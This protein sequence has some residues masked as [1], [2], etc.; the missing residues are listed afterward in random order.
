MR[1]VGVHLAD[2]LGAVRERAGEAG[3][4]GGAEAELA[5]AVEH[6]GAEPLGERAG[7]VGR[8]V[9]DD[10]DVEVLAGERLAGAGDHAGQARGLVVGGE[11]EPD[12]GAPYARAAWP[13]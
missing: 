7:A 8:G 10:E 9:V 6:L 12:G 1:A 5:R 3:D 11:D 13:T 2:E 4:V